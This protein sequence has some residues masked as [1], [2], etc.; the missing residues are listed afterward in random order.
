MVLHKKTLKDIGFII[1]I[2][3]FVILLGCCSPVVRSVV[4]STEPKV[5]FGQIN[6]LKN[7]K[8]WDP[9]FKMDS[10]QVRT[11]EGGEAGKGA[12]FH[13]KSSN[14]KISNGKIVITDSSPYDS[15][16]VKIL[17]MKG[18]Q[19]VKGTFKFKKADKGTNVIVEFSANN[20]PSFIDK[21]SYLMTVKWLGQK[22]EKGLVKLKKTC[23]NIPV[24]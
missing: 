16:R 6:N 18:N 5:V 7:W 10:T 4:I 9:F 8:N 15:I 20:N 23:E 12:G 13:W 22:F 3:G 24:K 17:F 14:R 11:F 2:G 19:Q 21:F 1:A